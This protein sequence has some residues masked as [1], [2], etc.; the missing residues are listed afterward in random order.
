MAPLPLLSAPHL[1]NQIDPSTGCSK[2]CVHVIAFETKAINLCRLP[3]ILQT[4]QAS[5][6]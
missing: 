6:L 2:A 4:L 5:T 3:N 1:I